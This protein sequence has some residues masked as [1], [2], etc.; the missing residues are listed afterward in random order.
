MGPANS[1]GLKPYAGE[2][3]ASRPYHDHRAVVLPL[4]ILSLI[5]SFLL[6]ILILILLLLLI[7]P[8]PLLTTIIFEPF[9]PNK[10]FSLNL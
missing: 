10:Y 4:L 5:L 1:L 7:L 8:P 3:M 6:F 9:E 2:I